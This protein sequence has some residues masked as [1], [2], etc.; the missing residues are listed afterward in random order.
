MHALLFF[1]AILHTVLAKIKTDHY[2]TPRLFD[3]GVCVRVGMDVVAPELC[4]DILFGRLLQMIMN[5]NAQK[6]GTEMTL[7]LLVL[8]K[9]PMPY[10]E[11]RFGVHADTLH[12]DTE[13]WL[14]VCTKHETSTGPHAQA[15][16]QQR[17]HTKYEWLVQLSASESV[18][19]VALYQYKQWMEQFQEFVLCSC[20]AVL[21]HEK[22]VQML[23]LLSCAERHHISVMVA[24][25][26]SMDWSMKPQIHISVGMRI[27]LHVM[28]ARMQ[29][30][31]SPL[32]LDSIKSAADN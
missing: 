24:G 1:G 28:H 32:G 8:K 11:W 10:S 14:A 2:I 29:D 15:V 31:F 26:E 3:I 6:P 9:T 19:L 18:C 16:F 17:M 22:V 7:L 5:S 27:F 13:A 20:A 4:S 21:C 25:L 23:Q 12:A 30:L